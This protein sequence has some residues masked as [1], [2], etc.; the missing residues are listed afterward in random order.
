M[1]CHICNMHF[2]SNTR[3]NDHMKNL[4]VFVLLY[5]NSCAFVGSPRDSA[6]HHDYDLFCAV[7]KS[8]IADSLW[9]HKCL[10]LKRVQELAFQSRKT[11]ATC[12]Q[13]LFSEAD[14]SNHAAS[15][16]VKKDDC[17]V[18]KCCD[19][20]FGD[21]QKQKVS[22]KVACTF[23][24]M[25]FSNRNIATAHERKHH[26]DEI[27]TCSRCSK[28]VKLA[29][30]KG[31]NTTHRTQKCYKNSPMKICN[32]CGVAVK[33]LQRHLTTHRDERKFKCSVCGKD[34]KLAWDMKKHLISHVGEAKHQ[35]SVCEKRFKF[36]YNMKVHMRIHESL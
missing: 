5:C 20:R 34:F 28:E 3:H 17:F 33:N 1:T 27:I 21:S 22:G 16:I 8:F 6:H 15:C 2:H 9:N 19:L 13:E 11:C 18:C 12:G 30:M 35:C 10:H 26:G 25:E 32:I 29:K 24:N 31:H 4:E 23:C 36:A 14:R 7:C